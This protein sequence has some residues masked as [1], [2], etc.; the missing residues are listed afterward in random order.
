VLGAGFGP[1]RA[2]CPPERIREK[3]FPLAQGA[4]IN[5]RLTGN[6]DSVIVALHGFGG[7]LDTWNGIEPFLSADHRFY[8][9][10]LP[11]YGLSAHPRHFGYTL[12][13][14][15]ESVAAFLQF[16]H[17]ENPGR[18]I[19]LI[20]H[21]FGGS[22]AIATAVLL[23]DQ[24]KTLVDSLILIDALGFP[25]IVHLPLSLNILRVPVLGHLVLTL[26]PAQSLAR[27]ALR[28]GMYRRDRVTN[29]QVCRFAQFINVEGGHDSLVRTIQQI[30]TPEAVELSARIPEIQVPTLIVWGS[31]DSLLSPDQAELLHR[32]LPG[33]RPVVL[34][35]AGHL[36]H[37]EL[38]ED[39]AKL[40]EEFLAQAPSRT[41]HEVPQAVRFGS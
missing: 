36:A 28:S 2:A 20:G 10:D 8:A 37:Q 13:E 11:G 40:I 31:H 25:Q 38:P 24:R 26:V 6:G 5:Y 18:K 16:V 4:Y 7:S 29:E 34:V 33:A 14:Q 41:F 19:T 15:S 17:D 27:S 35:E 21:S 39:T 30:R 1:I 32:A 22:I 9:I 23:L 12:K 3:T